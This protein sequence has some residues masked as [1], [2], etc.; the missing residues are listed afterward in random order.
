MREITAVIEDGKETSTNM[1]H[2]VRMAGNG[3]WNVSRE[4]LVNSCGFKK[5][6]S[7]NLSEDTEEEI[8]HLFSISDEE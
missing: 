8:V 1:L 7:S 2:G 3:L 4:T 5:N 6:T